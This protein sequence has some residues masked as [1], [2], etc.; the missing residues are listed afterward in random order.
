LTRTIDCALGTEQRLRDL[1][2]ALP[3]GGAELAIERQVAA[4]EPGAKR[5][6]GAPHQAG[7]GLGRRRQVEAQHLAADVEVLAVEDE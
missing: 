1:R 2:I 3:F 4:A 5:A 6:P 7:P